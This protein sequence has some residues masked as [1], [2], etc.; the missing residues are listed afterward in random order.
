MDTPQPP[1]DFTL[2]R[3]DK[4]DQPQRLPLA[5]LFVPW[6]KPTLAIALW[7][8]ALGWFGAYCANQHDDTEPET[9][10]AYLLFL[11]APIVV[12]ALLISLSHVLMGR[13]C[14]GCFLVLLFL[15]TGFLL[16]FYLVC[17]V[18]CFCA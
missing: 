8:L 15:F 10:L 4:T 2:F 16:F 18:V 5:R 11:T 13:G 12:F 9:Y 17:Y 14:G 3:R 7:M 6:W 1:Q